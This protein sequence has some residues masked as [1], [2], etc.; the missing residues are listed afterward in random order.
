MGRRGAESK[1]EQERKAA[2]AVAYSGADEIITSHELAKELE[3]TDDSVFRIETGVPSL[4]RIL[5]GVE[6][7]EL[8]VITGPTGEGKTTLL[9]TITSNL[10]KANVG[11][12]WFT[13]EV[14]PRQFIQKLVKA[15]ETLPL[16]FI[17]K[18]GFDDVDRA[19][20]EEFR[21]TKRREF[22][23]IDWIEYKIIEAK[24]KSKWEHDPWFGRE[25]KAVFI[26]HIHMIFSVSKVERSISLEIGDMV[27]EIKQMALKHGV[28]IFLIAHSK[29]APDGTNREPRKEDIRDSGLISRLADW[30]VGVWRIPNSDDGTSSRRKEV[31][32]G[33]N[34]SKVRV[35]KNRRVGRQGFFVMYH[36]NHQLTEDE[37]DGTGF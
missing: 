17:P 10:A 9:M 26:D 14:T 20:M 36:H 22:E 7:G 13:L 1:E 18:S 16:F 34:K 24:Q 28:A 25:V 19:F 29:D 3:K 11:S 37:W 15:N 30:I 23:M 2:E 21:R 8:G 27:A 12:L 6:V 31:N 35:F 4:D 32:E 33:D 5:D